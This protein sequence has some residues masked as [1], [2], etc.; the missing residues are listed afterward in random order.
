M[1]F[2]TDSEEIPPSHSSP[3]PAKTKVYHTITWGCIVRHSKS[4]SPM[5]PLG[6]KSKSES[7]ALL[8]ALMVDSGLPETAGN[9]CR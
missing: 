8:S 6:R 1:T 4:E 5:S 9:R 2:E 7:P 3:P